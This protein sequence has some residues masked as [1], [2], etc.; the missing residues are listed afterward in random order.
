MDCAVY[1]ATTLH[2]LKCTCSVP[3]A[4]HMQ[5]SKVSKITKSEKC[6]GSV[7]CSLQCTVYCIGSVH[8]SYNA[9]TAVNLQCTLHYT[10]G[11]LHFGLGYYRTSTPQLRGTPLLAMDQ[12]GEHLDIL[13]YFLADPVATITTTTMLSFFNTLTGHTYIW[14]IIIL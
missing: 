10:A 2:R 12:A 6:R 8:S 11:T 5:C 1:T 9:R 14:I 3:P 7:P 13:R 4:V